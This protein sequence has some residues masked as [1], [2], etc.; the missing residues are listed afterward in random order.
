MKRAWKEI[1][2]EKQ[3]AFKNSL[4]FT[5]SGTY[6]KK[7][8]EY[9]NFLH[10]SDAQN[11]GN[12]YCHDDAKEWKSLLEWS[13]ENKGERVDFT[14]ASMANMLRSEHIPYNLFYPLEKLRLSNPDLLI[15]FLEEL[16]G[17]GIKIESVLAIKIEFAGK[18]HKTDLLDDN[19]S[20]DAYIE[21]MSDGKKCGLGIEVKYTEK[22]YPYDKREKQRM[23]DQ[24]DSEYNSLSRKC[25]YYNDENL[26]D[27]KLEK[28]KQIWRN[29][30]LGIK[31]VAI[32]EL[33]EFHSM[34]I[35]PESNTYQKEASTE[36]IKCLKNK[37]EASFLPITFEKFISAAKKVFTDEPDL[38]WV[39]YLEDRY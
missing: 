1:A 23:F 36:Y 26:G 7:N 19:T 32:G 6:G 20:F 21:Y 37:K 8:K 31:M 29:H 3:I 5:K 15:V 35:F 24:P 17:Q 25:N 34:H 11:G 14:N 13:K 4:G 2:L 27:L 12:F 9:E 18:A 28:L 33:D 22:S 30:L 39:K 16:L 10:T 38:K